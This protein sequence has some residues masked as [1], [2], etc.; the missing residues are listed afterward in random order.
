[1]K[2]Q[3]FAAIDI[4]T[5]TCRLLIA[6]VDEAG[7]H[8]VARACAITNLGEGVDATGILTDAA[9][10]RVDEQIALYQQD[11]A[12]A[13]AAGRPVRTIAMATSASRD[14]RN[15]A[16][17]VALLERRGIELT[18]I[19]G[20]REAALS[21]KGASADYAGERLLV[22][23]IGG[24][25]TELIAGIG[26]DDPLFKHSFDIGCRRVTERFL[27]SDPPTP[28]E[29]DEAATWSHPQFRQF[30]DAVTQAGFAIE[31]VVAVAGTA[32]S[33]VSIDQSMVRYD[34][35]RV[36][37]T[38]VPAST[39]Q[40]IRRR[41]AALSVGERRAVV[42]L[43]PDRAPVIV[44]GLLILEDVLAQTGAGAFTVS[45]SDILQ[46]IIMDA[47]ER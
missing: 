3:R 46:G 37:G 5:V 26:G 36:N 20:E 35:A 38:V 14:A 28:A 10:R 29:I 15:A 22:A 32:T 43:Q 6:D 23:D 47:A 24:G 34:S 30:F 39:L 17:F 33:V 19:P 25:S 44:A 18:V 12:H 7:L 21:F 13:S 40:T 8:E 2:P 11:I 1:V 42:G 41:L 9:M 31:R 27:H 45:E 4:G 16:D